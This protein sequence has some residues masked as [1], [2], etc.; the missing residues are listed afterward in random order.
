MSKGRKDD[1]LTQYDP[2]RVSR[3]LV[4]YHDFM[5]PEARS[6]RKVVRDHKLRDVWDDIDTMFEHPEVASIRDKRFYDSVNISIAKKP[7]LQV[8]DREEG[9]AYDGEGARN[10][11]GLGDE[12]AG[13]P[14]SLARCDPVPPL[15]PTAAAPL[16]LAFPCAP[17]SLRQDGETTALV[18]SLC[19]LTVLENQSSNP[20]HVGA[21][22][23]R[24]ECCPPAPQ[25]RPSAPPLR[26]SKRIYPS[27]QCH[28]ARPHVRRP[29]HCPTG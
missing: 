10:D 13:G 6:S 7:S 16:H 22:G 12:T 20:T 3:I 8:V 19:K 25:P 28:Q 5:S 21:P 15:F 27:P 4:C 24:F 17:P 18:T 2:E 14:R 1:Q 11:L 29:F 23:P 26:K 9:R